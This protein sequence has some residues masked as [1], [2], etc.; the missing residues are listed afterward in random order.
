MIRNYIKIAVRTL[1]KNP[2]FSFIN[3]FGL[4]LSMSICMLVLLRV[5]DQFGYDKFHPNA[6]QTYRI[7][8]QL[9]NEK[10]TDYR[11]AGTP[12]PFLGYLTSNYNLIEK[13]TRIY[14]PG[15]QQV[16]ANKKSLELNGA[17]ADES[18]FS[19]FGFV[20]KSGNKLSALNA[21]NRI[22]LSKSSAER[23][24]GKE[25]DPVGQTIEY[26]KWGSFL[27]TGV[28]DDQPGKSHIQFDAYLSMNSVA[29]LERSGKMNPMLDTW[30]SFNNS[31][32][33]VV[34]KKGVTAKQ[35]ENAVDGISTT[36]MKAQ[37][38]KGS[39]SLKFEIQPFNKIILGEELMSSVGNT[40]SRG[41]VFAEIA[42][43]LIILI[44]ACFNYT[45]LS[46]ARSLNRG[47]EVGIRKV[48]G[49][50]RRH[51][52]LQ[53]IF[54]SVL[55]ALLSFGV[56]LMLLRL[57]MDYAPFI[58]EMMPENFVF[59]WSVFGWFLLFTLFAGLLAGVLPAWTL[60]SFKPVQVLKNLATVKLFGSNN[61]R[62]GL[63]V[64]QFTLSLVI[65]IFTLVFSRQF[66][67]M[68]NADPL[69]N[70]DNIL[71]IRLQ[72]TDPILLASE[73]KKLN[74][75]EQVTAVS[76][77]PGRN[78]SGTVSVK[79]LPSDQAID[80]EYYDVDADFPAV[81]DLKL[82][83]GNSFPTGATNE[84]EQYTI[85]NERALEMLKW[86]NAGEAVGQ[87]ILLNDT[88]PVRIVGV[89]K[90]FY[91][92]G[93]EWAPGPLLL[94]NRPNQYSQLLVRTATTNKEIEAA[95]ATVWKANYPYQEFKADWLKQKMSERYSAIGTL[96]ML[97]FLAF[98]TITIACL[99][100]LGMVTY[101]TQTRHKEI[102]I[103]KVMGADVITIMTILS[104]GFLKL[105]LI[106]GAIGLPLGY[107]ASFFFLNIFSNRVSIGVDI[108]LFSLLGMLVLVLLTIGTQIYRVAVANPVKALRAE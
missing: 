50:M 66:D 52:F 21:P 105:V 11:F 34:V 89:M 86:K 28:L 59:D 63:I 39:A 25:I 13:A 24:F 16:I 81:I 44:C 17:F 47:K 18:F 95:M 85:I 51:V 100:L 69:F 102:G 93:M 38:Q 67:Y 108:I 75:V 31:Y 84:K 79:Q 46:I 80:I 49:A 40:G 107:I 8:S 37:T 5:K 83:A 82:L 76:E 74:G 54:E 68:A 55:I 32:T 36:L 73:L 7:I 71:A 72:G 9:T 78:V 88:V 1:K 15:S 57:M 77:A 33:Y 26:T 43:S 12:L 101:L 23:L 60:S 58:G 96:S 56:A 22:V 3:I 27:V 62:K 64:V 45:N 106:A 30:D 48:A 4:A 65:V 35:L 91:F 19:I 70:R 90:N 53:F 104:K 99:G 14:L 87:Q 10:G 42:I 92:R 2:L 98:I 41:K 29:G 103:R 20:F 97:G 61:L 94:R 6:N